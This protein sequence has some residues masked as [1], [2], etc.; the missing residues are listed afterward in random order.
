MNSESQSSK[1][2][3]VVI[4]GGAMA[5]CTLALAINQFSKHLNIAILEQRQPP[6][7]QSGGFDARVIAL[8]QGTCQKFKQL[9]FSTQ[10][11]IW[12]QLS[13]HSC[14]I[15]HIH[16]SEKGHAARINISAGDLRLSRLGTVV[17]LNRM[18]NTLLE[19]IEEREN[20]DYLCP[21][22]V[23]EITHKSECV[24][25]RTQDTLYQAKLLVAADGNPSQT[26]LSCGFDYQL[27][28]DYGQTAIIANI[29]TEKDHQH[30]AYERFTP[31]GPLAMLPMAEKTMTLVWCRHN[32]EATLALSDDAFLKALQQE[33]G[34]RLGKLERVTQR[35]AYPLKLQRSTSKVQTRTALVGN[36]AQLLHPI[37]GQGFNLAIR[38]CF[39]LAKQLAELPQD[40]D[41]GHWDALQAYQKNRLEDQQRL[42]QL[43]DGLVHTFSNPYPELAV[44]RNLG[45]LALSKSNILQQQFFKT[46]LGWL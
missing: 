37:A 22:Q 1:N 29:K 40:S 19:A 20:I 30:C 21:Q 9:K 17:E 8:S 41:V 5:G 45:L 26:A 25:I 42:I 18:G 28:S 15:E 31:Q 12:Q 10:H 44:A 33:F 11:S 46:T 7:H 24:E 6:K 43:T 36:A 13:Q 27:I 16:T 39:A 4:V 2:Y 34:W 14:D 23:K 32:P 3:D 35:F 38:D